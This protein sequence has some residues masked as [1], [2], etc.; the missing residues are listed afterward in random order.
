MN[1]YLDNKPVIFNLSFQ[2]GDDSG[3]YAKQFI[4]RYGT[5]KELNKALNKNKDKCPSRHWQL[6]VEFEYI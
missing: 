4:G 3:N 6:L 5:L 1:L 2:T